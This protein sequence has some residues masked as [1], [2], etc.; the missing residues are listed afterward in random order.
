[1]SHQQLN[2]RYNTKKW[3][4]QR[5]K[6][7]YIFIDIWILQ[8]AT[9]A[10][11]DFILLY[12]RSTITDFTDS[13]TPPPAPR[14][15]ILGYSLYRNG[16]AKIIFVNNTITI[17]FVDCFIRSKHRTI[18]DDETPSRQ[19]QANIWNMVLKICVPPRDQYSS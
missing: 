4:D 7:N 2:L 12:L 9:V 16:I 14:S 19:K 3:Q 5:S 11:D 15:R 6:I 18:V 1:M 8:R 13:I 10:E 17:I